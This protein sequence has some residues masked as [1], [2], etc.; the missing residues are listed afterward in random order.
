MIEPYLEYAGFL[1]VS[2]MLG[3]CK[4]DPTLISVLLNLS[5]DEPVIMGT[6]VVGIG[7]TFCEQL[8]EKVAATTCR[9]E[10]SGLTQ[11]K[12]SRVGDV[13]SR[14]I[15]FRQASPSSPQDIGALHKVDLQE[16]ID[17]DWLK[18]HDEYINI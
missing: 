12:I 1:H 17:E 7:A 16:R 6:V 11:L 5:M 14:D 13:V 18:S 9:L 4:L 2:P 3:G 8:L 10:R 15:K